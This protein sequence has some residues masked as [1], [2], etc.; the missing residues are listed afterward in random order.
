MRLV[1]VNHAH[2][3]VPHVSGMRLAYFAREMACRG[4]QVVLLTC[5]LPGSTA[6]DPTGPSLTE[7]LKAHDWTRPMV[8]AIP[9]VRRRALDLIRHNRVP[10]IFRR[11]MTAWQF[12]IHGGMFA[13]WHKAAE[14]AIAQ[15]SEEFRPDVVWG[16]F[17]NTT[18]LSIA[19]QLARRAR[20]PWVA[21][22]KDSWTAFV[23][24]G[25]RRQV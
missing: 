19:R 12:V 3:D 24:R 7:Q 17:G 25:L 5:A 22:I 16:A 9:P 2:P 4:H 18:N 6:A 10:A 1:F 23:P 13:D 15:L 11:P 14:C 8:V 21:D 20:C